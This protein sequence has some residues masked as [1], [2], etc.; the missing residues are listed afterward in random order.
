MAQGI[1]RPHEAVDFAAIER[2]L[3]EGCLFFEDWVGQFQHAAK[4][5]FE[6]CFATLE[7]RI[8]KCFKKDV[9]VS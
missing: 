5:R 7:K 2:S 4:S 8:L 6:G 3:T 1:R 9:E